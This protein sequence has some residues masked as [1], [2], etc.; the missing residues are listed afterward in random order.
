MNL[1]EKIRLLP[2]LIMVAMLA[3]AVRVGDFVSGLE[4]MGAAQAQSEV[5]VEPPPMTGSRTAVPEA[6][7]E[8]EEIEGRLDLDSEGADIPLKPEF[9]KEAEGQ[10]GMAV[11]PD[12]KEAEKV[13]WKDAADTDIDSSVVKDELYKD[14][15]Q[16]RASLDKKEKEITVREA[17][18][19][20]AERELDQKLRELNSIRTEIETAMKKQSEEEQARIL[21]LVK[22]YEGMKPKDAA[23]IMNTLDID[24]LMVILT[25]MSER[26]SSSILAE[27]NPERARTVT[28]MM[29][30]QRQIPLLTPETE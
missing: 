8:E 11:L 9:A 17:L 24:V 6:L 22:I 25:K 18:L 21:S 15:A 10:G 20:A 23:S 16:R 26:K 28:T 1:K 13:D 30:D 29:A 2:V 5:S 3:F 14:L 7:V 12:M 19:S 4:N 27:M